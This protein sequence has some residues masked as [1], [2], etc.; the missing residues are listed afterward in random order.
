[1]RVGLHVR[2]AGGY[3]KAIEH[4]K[5]AGC[6]AL[7]V[8]SS[9]PRSYRPA[10]ID[11]PSRRRSAGRYYETRRC[12]KRRSET[13][14]SAESARRTFRRS[15]TSEMS[16]TNGVERIGSVNMGVLDLTVTF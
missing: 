6:T 4:A 1:M 5:A 8:F 3:A 10:A 9:N 14:Y 2:V 13:K 16:W 12:G 15:V 7:Q 11:V